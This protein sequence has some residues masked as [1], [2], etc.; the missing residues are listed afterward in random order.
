MLFSNFQIL[1]SS[2][3]SSKIIVLGSIQV[4]VSGSSVCDLSGGK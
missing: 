1:K 4:A 2:L 3:Q